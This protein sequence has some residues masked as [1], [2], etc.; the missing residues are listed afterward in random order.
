MVDKSSDK[1]SIR[2]QCEL[3][4]VHRS[5]V[6][7]VPCKEEDME[8]L[9]L[10]YEIYIKYP[11]YGYRRIKVLLERY[12][13]ILNHKT[14]SRIMKRLGIKAIYQKPRTSINGNK[15][16]K[17]PYLLKSLKIDSP[18]K[19]WQVDITYMKVTSGYMYISAII[20]VYSR[21]ILSHRISNSLCKESVLLTLEDAL[22]M[23]PEPEIINT[24]Q[25]CQF[26]S[27]DWI[28]EL[29]KR[30]IKISMTGQ[31]RC[32][33]NVYIERL[34]RSMKYEGSYLYVWETVKDLKKNI[35]LWVKW[36]NEERPHQS[37]DYMTPSDKY[38]NGNMRKGN[39]LQTGSLMAYLLI[40]LFH[41]ICV[42]P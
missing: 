35:P 11:M 12:G 14:V 32:C 22:L 37:I 7:R 42:N 38:D 1:L 8:L 34:W 40:S 33:D 2:S 26:T 20:D 41:D 17:Y 30:G 10:I 19:V 23:Y 18:N 25:G 4:Q 39:Q 16:Y 5:S 6:Y 31:G 15:N 28:M 27:E 21:R 9:N 24:D 13:Y 36:Y 29:K 3:L